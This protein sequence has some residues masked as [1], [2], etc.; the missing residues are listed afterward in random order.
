MNKS[1]QGKDLTHIFSSIIIGAGISGITFAHKLSQKGEDVLVLEKEKNAGGQINTYYPKNN[2]GFRVESGAHTLYNSYAHLLSV[3]EEIG[4]VDNILPLQSFPYLIYQ[5]NKIKSP[6]SCISYIP[7]MFNGLNIFFA[8]KKGKTVKEYFKSIVG[9]SNYEKLFTYMFRAVISQEADEYPADLF[10]K[11]RN[12]R[13]KDMPR[14]FSFQRGLSGLIEEIIQTDQL[15]VKTNTEV[16]E[17][18]YANELYEVKTAAGEIYYARSIGIATNTPIA[19]KLLQ[20][21]DPSTSAI[22]KDILTSLSET[23]TIVVEPDKVTIKP[24]AGIIPTSN[25]FN[26]AVSSDVAGNTTL[27]GFSFHFGKG[28]KTN[29]EKIDMACKVL[30]IQPEDILE[31]SFSSHILPALRIKDLGMIERIDKA[32]SQPDI[33]I[34]GNYFYGMSLE[35]CVQRST[36]EAKRYFS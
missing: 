3:V 16:T 10:L 13:R 15:Q 5:D 29:E 25:D 20:K 21:V 6:F 31:Q 1:E 24:V 34:L 8:S 23:L 12:G 19:A 28:N 33:Y 11:R 9:K 30:G 26:S 22:L 32:R 18:Q 35:D 36:E 17:V 27:R 14:K 4:A 7:L 2:S